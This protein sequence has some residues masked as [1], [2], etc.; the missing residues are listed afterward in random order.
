MPIDYSEY[1]SNWLTE[2]RPRILQRAH[3]CCE[4]CGAPNYAII[5]RDL[6]SQSWRLISSTEHE[7]LKSKVRSGYTHLQAIKKLG[8]TKIIL[9]IAHL[10]HDKENHQVQDDE[11]KAA[12]QRCHLKYD[13][14]RH[15]ENRKYG[16]NRNKTQVKLF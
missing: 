7:W 3:N 12:C 6:H 10:N 1:P 16:R 4:W 8:F 5:I 15:I 9:T 13:H 2:I 11:L 14:A